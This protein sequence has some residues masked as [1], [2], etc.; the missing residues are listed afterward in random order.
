M[1]SQISLVLQ[2]A[3]PHYF[4]GDQVTFKVSVTPAIKTKRAKGK[5]VCDAFDTPHEIAIH[6]SE[7]FTRTLTQAGSF[8]AEFAD[9]N[10][11][12]TEKTGKC[13]ASLEVKP[14]PQVQFAYGAAVWAE[15]RSG[16][17]GGQKLGQ[18]KLKLELGDGYGGAEELHPKGSRVRITGPALTT[19]SEHDLSKGLEVTVNLA[20]Q[21]PQRPSNLTLEV[22]DRVEIGRRATLE[23]DP[24]AP[25]VGLAL[26]NDPNHPADEPYRPEQVI[27]LELKLDY[28]LEE[29][30]HVVIRGEAL[31]GGKV[32]TT[33]RPQ[34]DL[35]YT[36]EAKIA[37]QG[38][39]LFLEKVRGEALMLDELADRI[40]IKTAGKL[41]IEL[42]KEGWV[43]PDRK[44]FVVDDKVQIT[45]RLSASAPSANFY[46][47]NL[48]V[49]S[50]RHELRFEEGTTVKTLEVTLTEPGKEVKVHLE[51]A[52][53]NAID[54]SEK[55]RKHHLHV[56]RKNKASFSKSGW[57]AKVAKGAAKHGRRATKTVRG[58][59]E[60]HYA[61]E[62]VLIKI[63]LA[64]PLELLENERSAG[65]RELE[66]GTL[67]CNHFA[68]QAGYPVLIGDG[69]KEAEVEVTFG[70]IDADAQTT[71]TLQTT[72]R[73]RAKP[74]EDPS[75]TTRVLQRR[76]IELHP[77]AIAK[78]AGQELE[79]AELVAGEEIHFRL[80]LEGA[81]TTAEPGG[82][83]YVCTKKKRK[84][85]NV[86]LATLPFDV[87][88]DA[89]QVDVPWGL[90]SQGSLTPTPAEVYVVY[91]PSPGFKVPSKS[92]R[93]KLAFEPTPTLS[94]ASPPLAPDPDAPK[95]KP[96][97][98]AP[99]QG[100]Q[101]GGA[102]GLELRV[103]QEATFRLELSGS[104]RPPAGGAKALINSPAFPS[105]LRIEGITLGSWTKTQ[106]LH[107]DLATTIRLPPGITAT[108]APP[109]FPCDATIAVLSGCKAPTAP[110]NALKLKISEAP[111]L[112][113][114][115]LGYVLRQNGAAWSESEPLR[116]KEAV[117][118]VLEATG[119]APT[120][121]WEAE[122]FSPALE[123]PVP[124]RFDPA[125]QAQVDA[126][127]QD[128]R[129]EV[130]LTFDQ[131]APSQTTITL[132]T[133]PA[134]PSLPP[135]PPSPVKIGRAQRNLRFGKGLNVTF[136]KFDE[137]EWFKPAGPFMVGDAVQ[138]RL[139]LSGPHT[140]SE[141]YVAA[142][143]KSLAFKP[144]KPK[145]GQP[146]PGPLDP[147]LPGVFPA[148]VP[149][150]GLVH[151]V[152]FHIE[153]DP[154]E[155]G[156]VELNLDEEGTSPYVPSDKGKQVLSL[157]LR[158]AP[159]VC[160]AP[161]QG[162]LAP[163]GEPEPPA[164]PPT[165]PNAPVDPN[166]PPPPE[167]EVTYPTVV[168]ATTPLYAKFSGPVP[169]RGAK[170]RVVSMPEGLLCVEGT[171]YDQHGRPENVVHVSHQ[172][173]EDGK[174]Q[175]GTY[176][177][178]F[179]VVFNHKTTP[180]QPTN[181]FSAPYTPQ[182]SALTDLAEKQ[183][184]QRRRSALPPWN[185]L[186]L[187][188]MREQGAPCGCTVDPLE[189]TQLKVSVAGSSISFPTD[190][191][192]W[193]IKPAAWPDDADE[194][195]EDMHSAIFN[196]LPFARGD[197]VQLRLQRNGG[198]PPPPPGD[199][200][201][202]SVSQLIA[203]APNPGDKFLVTDTAFL[204]GQYA[205]SR[206]GTTAGLPLCRGE[207]V[208]HSTETDSSG[209]PK[210]V[211]QKVA[212]TPVLFAGVC[213][214]VSSY[215]FGSKRS[216][217]TGAERP[218]S[219]SVSWEEGERLS[220][221]SDPFRLDAPDLLYKLLK[222]LA[223][224]GQQSP[225]FLAFA[226]KLTG[227]PPAEKQPRY[228]VAPV[229]IHS[230]IST[231]TPSSERAWQDSHV[232]VVAFGGPAPGSE[233]GVQLRAVR[234]VQW[235]SGLHKRKHRYTINEEVTL[236]A[237]LNTFAPDRIR[238]V[239]HS[240]L[241]D[242][243]GGYAQE[244]FIERGCIEGAVKV[245]PARVTKLHADDKIRLTDQ[246]LADESGTAQLEGI[247]T[248]YDLTQELV[249]LEVVSTPD[250]HVAK[251]LR[252]EPEGFLKLVKKRK[253]YK[254]YKVER[255]TQETGESNFAYQGRLRQ[256]RIDKDD[257]EARKLSRRP[258]RDE[259]ETFDEFNQRLLSWESGEVS[260]SGKEATKIGK[261]CDL[262]FQ[263]TLPRVSFAKEGPFV[264]PPK[265]KRETV[266]EW[267]ERITHRK[268][269]V[270]AVFG[271]GDRFK[272]A[273]E[274]DAP[275]ANGAKV[276]VVCPAF[277]GHQV[278]EIGI[279]QNATYHEHELDIVDTYGW[280][281]LELILRGVPRTGFTDG[282]ESLYIVACD[283][284]A[285]YLP[286][287]L[288][289]D[290]D[291]PSVSSGVSRFQGQ[292][293]WITPSGPYAHHDRATVV[294]RLTEPAGSEGAKAN[295]TCKAFN[296]DY[297]VDFAPG[298][299]QAEVEVEFGKKPKTANQF[300]QLVAVEGCVAGF[301][302]TLPIEVFPQRSVYFPPRACLAPAGPFVENDHATFSIMMFPEAPVGGAKVTLKG[303]FPDEPLEFEEGQCFL[304]KTVQLKREAEAPQVVELEPVEGCSLGKFTSF[305]LVVRK[306][307]LRF[308]P[309]LFFPEAE[310][311]VGE[312]ISVALRLLHPAPGPKPPDKAALDELRKAV[313]E[314][315]QE[316][317]EAGNEMGFATL[318]GEIDSDH[319][320]E[321]EQ[322]RLDAEQALKDGEKL[323]QGT[324]YGAKVTLRC[325]AFVEPEVEGYFVA[326][327]T[328]LQIPV[329]IKPEE[330]LA[331]A[332][333]TIEILTAKCD[334][335]EVGSPAEAKFTPI[336]SPYVC[337]AT[338]AIVPGLGVHT[339]GRESDEVVYQVGQ[340][341]TLRITC[342]ELPEQ[343]FQ[344][345]VRSP[346]F[347]G[348]VYLAQL[349]K[350]KGHKPGVA[351]DGQKK[352]RKLIPTA[353]VEVTFTRGIEDGGNAKPQRSIP[354][355]L[356]P[357]RGWRASLPD[358]GEPQCELEV[359]VLAPSA[360]TSC[361]YETQT[362][363]SGQEV[364]TW[365]DPY[366]DPCNLTKALLV[367]FH[368]DL[369]PDPL[370]APAPEPA[371]DPTDPNA[372]P[373]PETHE[374]KVGTRETHLDVAKGTTALIPSKRG[375]FELVR[376][377]SDAD[378]PALALVYKPGQPPVLQVIAGRQS[379]AE[380]LD[381]KF[382]ATH[383]SVQLPRAKWC[384]H[385]FEEIRKVKLPKQQK[386]LEALRARLP[387][388]AQQALGPE[389]ATS[390]ILLRHH[391]VVNLQAR[392]ATKFGVGKYSGWK[393]VYP[394]PP[395]VRPQVGREDDLLFP[396][397]TSEHQ[398]TDPEL[399][400]LKPGEDETTEKG[401]ATATTF[402]LEP[403][404]Q[405]YQFMSR[406]S[407]PQLPA[408]SI[409]Q[410]LG[411]VDTALARLGMGPVSQEFQD[412]DNV[413]GD[414]NN[415]LGTANQGLTDWAINDPQ[416]GGE[417][418]MSAGF[419]PATGTFC[420]FPLARILQFVSF[421]AK[422]KQYLLSVRSCGEPDVDAKEPEQPSEDLQCIVEVFPSDEFNLTYSF[423][424]F[425]DTIQMGVEGRYVDGQSELK[426][427]D[428][429]EDYDQFKEER[430]QE[431]EANDQA[432]VNHQEAHD[433]QHQAAVDSGSY[434]PRTDG[435]SV[436]SDEQ[437][438]QLDQIVDNFQATSMRN[439]DVEYRAELTIPNQQELETR[440]GQPPR[441]E[442]VGK[443][444]PDQPGDT[445]VGSVLEYGYRDV[446]KGKKPRKRPEEDGTH[447]AVPAG[448]AP[449]WKP[450]KDPGET[451]ALKTKVFE[452][453]G[454][455]PT[456]L[457]PIPPED[458]PPPPADPWAQM[459]GVCQQR[460][461]ERNAWQ[462]E[463]LDN[464]SSDVEG[465]ALDQQQHE[466]GRA[467]N[468]AGAASQI[469]NATN[470]QQAENVLNN[471]WTQ[472][473]IALTNNGGVDDALQK[474]A[475]GLLVGLNTA[476]CFF[477]L[478]TRLG[479]INVSFGFGVRFEVA[480]LEGALTA[481]WGF[482]ESQAGDYTDP[483][484]APLQKK[485]FPWYA[486]W[487]D[488]ILLSLRFMIDFGA[489][490]CFGWLRF[491]FVAYLRIQLDAS[492]KSGF[493]RRG[494]DSVLP[495][496]CD[497]W[498][499]A[500]ASTDLGLRL[501]L[502]SE[503]ICSADAAIKTGLELR[504]RFSLP[505]VADVTKK[506]RK[507]SGR[508]TGRF[509]IEYEV[510]FPGVVVV[511]NARILSGIKVMKTWTIME[512]NPPQLPL[513]RGIFP[514]S[515]SKSFWNARQ[516]LKQGW[517]KMLHQKRRIMSRVEQWQE[518]Q[519]AMVAASGERKR[520][521][522]P[523]YPLTTVSPGLFYSGDPKDEETRQWWEDNKEKWL[524]QWEACRLSFS[525]EA[526]KVRRYGQNR[527]FAPKFVPRTR[528][529]LGEALAYYCAGVEDLIERKLTPRLKALNERAELLKQF[530]QQLEE[531][532]N[533]ADQAEN[534]SPKLM[535]AIKKL[536][537]ADP[538][539]NWRQSISSR[540]LDM[541]DKYLLRIGYYYPQREAW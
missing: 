108:G 166:A 399:A 422:P 275:A 150:D 477:E 309:Q 231:R 247:G 410:A 447:G 171:G 130:Q 392:K 459:T 346:A 514:N 17:S 362:D 276:E 71:I 415:V 436:Y 16:P 446:L 5:V 353:E 25:L 135:P 43:S 266:V 488:L 145:P 97:A 458:H 416:T 38:P 186:K 173:Y 433:A 270:K 217:T 490:A 451:H 251:A 434:D 284:P 507:R 345:Q 143:L 478:F 192:E 70:E 369:A 482:K 395:D 264:D 498:W 256:W 102:G 509:A 84:T 101:R 403:Q 6:S 494:P 302:R 62:Q 443:L 147:P 349:R 32:R 339:T 137:G 222:D 506:A 537:G 484:K 165:D 361:P 518:L 115:E 371:P 246:N 390:E 159:T 48:H 263:V 335:L 480:F 283:L 483:S 208:G 191:G 502:V 452:P 258:I 106:A 59:Q 232:R 146:K 479:D 257:Y 129:L 398:G 435:G 382:H 15:D 63:S 180:H 462:Q 122:L 352:V 250:L 468:T 98:R 413:T 40:Q 444:D 515:A 42:P 212:G 164:P 46:A 294:V 298:A 268:K 60:G 236:H 47:A 274:L 278:V 215:A 316:T 450:P 522:S 539:L 178:P 513:K 39:E 379:G 259:E 86:D 301:G 317:A 464:A 463:N 324:D 388:E 489:K 128:H 286:K 244:F 29:K 80:T 152:L 500:K 375:P 385:Q 350:P 306:P 265:S 525:R 495:A 248:E 359:W 469:V 279:P 139:E 425:P 528:R 103:G 167:P 207:W 30:A 67:V 260:E 69:G 342:E 305:E 239:V 320:E 33:L 296:Q 311:R 56:H 380:P 307:E 74:G 14:L 218:V 419:D 230:P 242:V 520:D 535:K 189:R 196:H 338:P 503:N 124:V 20:Y 280:R 50:A 471:T 497:T 76:Q 486:L 384:R 24:R 485:V 381:S 149:K 35:T 394:P 540:P 155:S 470:Q 10:H 273:I 44:D 34:Q 408:P 140:L 234:T 453:V 72:D 61:G 290:Q 312:E 412:F 4:V 201:T 304:A 334:R 465:W 511:L 292:P 329:R 358:Q 313:K 374:A 65:T 508:A 68:E 319:A 214:K 160:F 105:A 162:G 82:T 126:W 225:A 27:K 153:V 221:P 414:V 367:Q 411:P 194:W 400:Q 421:F 11:R 277:G 91:E 541:I 472:A 376:R 110:G 113:F 253:H 377:E 291:D 99:N 220:L 163:D 64:Y 295:L 491:E 205:P 397:P 310:A 241:F 272:L 144:P 83:I 203:L 289:V 211:W 357:P 293:D 131:E 409:V 151:D 127:N 37:A 66:I 460:V 368:G 426:A 95:L 461:D 78:E 104:S 406:I 418:D 125:D 49:G 52:D 109:T 93:I 169:R 327:A 429:N 210:A 355:E 1:S 523:V 90:V 199:P 55:R 372:E 336:K 148:E 216:T 328:E 3:K 474:V 326:G 45:A 154:V 267:V 116:F 161:Q 499:I 7:T 94:F 365:L 526:H 337:F 437:N 89:K 237:V 396:H 356:V 181:Y 197:E 505:D 176:L 530:E 227:Q 360:E 252:G 297:A 235:D 8:T 363:S 512:G 142:K 393:F 405:L 308:A 12:V 531:E 88:A 206:G 333:Q 23:V 219:I 428:N 134:D 318:F 529:H 51:S 182:L 343:S 92:G 448:A 315:E 87:P 487:V 141:D 440:Y 401:Y 370:T 423:Q 238:C 228:P 174:L 185:S 36:V 331:D 532:E 314:A 538:V 269:K 347:G 233:R 123:N 254:G 281:P 179:N 245:K 303:P 391:P 427:W 19:S 466:T 243:D 120:V 26:A 348:K 114:P 420:N 28:P 402:T 481:Y 172:E 190:E 383:L 136:A 57:I 200:S 53:P 77:K 517:N 344:V 54:V 2:D 85:G 438:A 439:T 175:D 81:S 262:K 58:K 321:V 255:P 492:V 323:Y 119:A 510:H 213:A 476:R 229:S 202:K 449:G 75:K 9:L 223:T 177:H 198:D 183:K 111:Q 195:T 107:Q 21:D 496:W 209:H 521:G 240:L 156:Q 188:M 121:V 389:V 325:D 79:V 271:K 516:C 457:G 417:I 287:P 341:A 22:L 387:I 41:E 112:S 330:T 454:Y 332:E 158:T 224:A 373:A 184:E 18:A 13:K 430:A 534:P 386:L 322:R 261:A 533:N 467:T 431:R 442:K 455:G 300:L 117:T 170:F 31:K 441:L 407:V 378:D 366:V 73:F 351:L 168:G 340:T 524:E 527:A 404:E 519:L 157:P 100:Q 424:P 473:T 501:V 226:A 132:R 118:V 193:W 536:E 96:G 475:D 187:T 204:T 354:I 288:D 282:W 299:D 133:P 456:A 138:V 432:V 364:V 504:F 445:K 249:H 493:E 285:V